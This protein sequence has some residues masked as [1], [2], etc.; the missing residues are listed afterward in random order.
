[1]VGE[2]TCD[3][4]AMSTMGQ[5]DESKRANVIQSMLLKA[6]RLIMRS[7]EEIYGKLDFWLGGW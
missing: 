5:L 1:M 6:L 4:Q 7:Y 3:Y 2:V